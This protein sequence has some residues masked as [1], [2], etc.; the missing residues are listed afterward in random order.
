LHGNLS[1]KI[2]IT[3]TVKINVKLQLHFYI[4][5]TNYIQLLEKYLMNYNQLQLQI[6]ITPTLNYLL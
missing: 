2:T 6:T 1:N 4:P 3:I 5:I